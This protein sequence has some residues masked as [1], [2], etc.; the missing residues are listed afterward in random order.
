[1]QLAF[2]ADVEAFR[3]EFVAFLDEHLPDE[4]ETVQR[5]HSSSDVPNDR[6]DA[7]MMPT[8]CGLK[9]R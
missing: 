5:S 8:P 2:D 6:I 9:L 3:A 4:A 7:A 1:M